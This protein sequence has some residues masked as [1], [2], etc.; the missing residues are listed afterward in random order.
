MNKCLFLTFLLLLS[1]PKIWSSETIAEAVIVRGKVT[2][3]E[4]GELQAKVVKKGTKFKKDASILT[5]PRSF[6]RIKF[7]DQSLA[8]LGPKS[9]MVVNQ[10]GKKRTGFI[11]LIKGKL[12]TKVI[13][14]GTKLTKEKN[15]HTLFIKTTTASL[16]V[17]G[18]DFQVV[19]NSKNKVTSLLTYEGEVQISKNKFTFGCCVYL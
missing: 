4:L 13:K 3:L 10:V 17:R 19:Y 6:I 12:R 7:K 18:T 8:S 2:V 15:S 11:S 14:K 1:S 16:G 5:G 9:K